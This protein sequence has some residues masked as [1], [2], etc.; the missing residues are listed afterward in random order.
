MATHPMTAADA[1]WYHM[2]GPANLAIVT[3]VL[4]TRQPLDF[5]KVRQ[6]C[7]ERLLTFDRFSQRL[8]TLRSAPHSFSLPQFRRLVCLND[9]AIS[10]G[11]G[12]QFGAF[13]HPVGGAMTG[14]DQWTLGRGPVRSRCLKKFAADLSADR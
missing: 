10:P 8:A 2:D 13:R 5:D 9:T 14:R 12:R 4:L 6:V 3:G 1:A 7:R 11:G